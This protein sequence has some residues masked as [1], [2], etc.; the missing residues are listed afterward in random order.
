MLDAVFILLVARLLLL[1]L[2]VVSCFLGFFAF[3]SLRLEI[4]RNDIL[5]PSGAHTKKL[6]F[7]VKHVVVLTRCWYAQTPCVYARIRMLT[8]A[9]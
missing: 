5:T 3:V 9:R 8:Y 6:F 1:L 7:L 4:Q 2:M